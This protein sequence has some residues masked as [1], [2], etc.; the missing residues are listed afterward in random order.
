MHLHLGGLLA[1]VDA[2]ATEHGQTRAEAIRV[3]LALAL[4]AENPPAPDTE[5]YVRSIHDDRD[6]PAWGVVVGHPDEDH[7]LVVWFQ[8][9]YPRVE[10]MDELVPRP[11]RTA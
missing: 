11:P 7:A 10:P 3:L 6:V 4:A 8:G 9:G 5:L 2:Y 1:P